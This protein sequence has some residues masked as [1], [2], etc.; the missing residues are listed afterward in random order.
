MAYE[1]P[2]H[3]R[4]NVIKIRVNDDEYDLLSACANL[5]RKQKATLAREWM[6]AEMKRRAA[7]DTGKTRIA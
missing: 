4:R 1:N 3:I 5:G 6:L 2:R 7:L